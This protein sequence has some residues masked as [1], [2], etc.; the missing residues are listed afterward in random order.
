MN[1]TAFLLRRLDEIGEALSKSSTALALIG[2]GSV[3]VELDRLD[4]YS[5]LDFY[6]IVK[7]GSKPQYLEDLSWLSEVTPI[8]YAFANTQDGYKLLFDD[9]IFCEFAVF[10][11]AELRATTF[12]PGRIVWKAQGVDE[13]LGIPQQSA[14]A[15]QPHSADWLVGEAL[16]N[17]YVGLLRDLRGEKL[18]AMRFIQGYAI[19]RILEL[20]ERVETATSAHPD[21]F[22]LERRYEERYPGMAWL[23]PGFLQGYERNRQSALATLA[24]LDERFEV[25]PAMG[26]AVLRLCEGDLESKVE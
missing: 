2:L 15:P 9:G 23:L 25:N 7:P 11:E 24:F 18:S 16:T 5:D 21:P 20:S 10:E 8:A 14:P 17:L 13:A 12:A 4:R 26:Q 19:D 1:D 6:V 3:G 22:N